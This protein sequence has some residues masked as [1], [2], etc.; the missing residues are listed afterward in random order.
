[1][2][3]IKF[4]RIFMYRLIFLAACLLTLLVSEGKNVAFSSY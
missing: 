3:S 4:W 2:A 1:M